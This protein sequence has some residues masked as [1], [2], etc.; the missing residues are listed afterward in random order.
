MFLR[1]QN[2]SLKKE[3]HLGQDRGAF[4]AKKGA[5][6]LNFHREGGGSCPHLPP[7]SATGFEEMPLN[8]IAVMYGTLYRQQ[9]TFV[10]IF[11]VKCVCQFCVW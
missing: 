5:S 1:I 6:K 8:F 10:C 2:E 9:L 7:K 3:G 11:C 4:L